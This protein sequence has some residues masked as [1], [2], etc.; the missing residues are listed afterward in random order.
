[1]RRNQ[2]DSTFWMRLTSELLKSC[3]RHETD[4]VD[5]VRFSDTCSIRT[6][7]NNK[8]LELAASR[9]FYRAPLVGHDILNIDGLDRAYGLFED[10]ISTDLFVKL[11]AYR[12][13]GHRHVRLPLNCGQYWELRRSLHTYVERIG[14]ITEIPIL[15]SLDLCNV[16]SIRLHTHLL[17]L[18][19]TFLLEQSRCPRADIGVCAGDVVIDAGG[20]WGDTA[21]YFAKT[22]ERVFCFECMPSNIAIIQENLALNPTLSAKISVVQKALWSRSGETVVFNDVGP[23]SRPASSGQGVK[24]ETQT[25]DDFVLSNSVKR[26]D[27]IKMDIEGSEPDALIGAEWTIRNYRPRL[28]ISIYH[29]ASHFASIPAWLANLNLGYRLYLDHFTIHQEETVL[30]ARSTK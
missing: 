26:I 28:G 9:G 20:C 19:N 13:L 16:H 14:T 6:A 2:P 29:D 23:G 3:Y 24:V 10:E 22:A 30:F 8:L 15:G 11:L 27:F 18:L 21:L 4:N 7:V 17:A 5:Q 25:I 1:M 12:V